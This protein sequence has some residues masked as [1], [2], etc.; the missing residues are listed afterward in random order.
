[1]KVND[2]ELEDGSVAKGQ[3]VLVERC[4]FLSVGVLVSETIRVR[5]SE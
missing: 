2:V 3:G 5:S 1:M 4:A